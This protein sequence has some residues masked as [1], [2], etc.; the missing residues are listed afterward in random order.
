MWLQ[1]DAV[2]LNS[3]GS[4]LPVGQPTYYL[5]LRGGYEILL[6][7]QE[8]WALPQSLSASA[9]NVSDSYPNDFYM[10]DF[11]YRLIGIEIYSGLFYYLN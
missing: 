11:T 3:S 10:F 4:P 1:S 6:P 2:T 8:V 5:Y 9:N 7:G